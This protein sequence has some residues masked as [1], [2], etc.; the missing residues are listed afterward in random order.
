ML[1]SVLA[2]PRRDNNK[3]KI[4]SQLRQLNTIAVECVDSVHCFS[5]NV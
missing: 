5:Q 3:I 1:A 2:H 4:K